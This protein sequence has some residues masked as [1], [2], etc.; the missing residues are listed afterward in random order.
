MKSN[1]KVKKTT[2]DEFKERYPQVY[3]HHKEASIVSEIQ[4]F[5]ERSFAYVFEFGNGL[6]SLVCG[7]RSLYNRWVKNQKKESQNE[8]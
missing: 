3:L 4:L 8:R 5:S 1:I 6:T 2:T 7:S